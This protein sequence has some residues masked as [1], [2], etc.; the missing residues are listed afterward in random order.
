M[1]PS[2]L[3]AASRF[4]CSLSRASPLHIN[5]ARSAA[6]RDL[7]AE[8]PAD[9]APEAP[10][11]ALAP[12]VPPAT[13][14]PEVPPALAAPDA[15]PPLAALPCAPSTAGGGAEQTLP[16]ARLAQRCAITNVC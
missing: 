6:V 14:A 4:I 5:E 3:P 8:A 11:A 12:E 15:P 16:R 9:P 2:S 13:A 1:A 10:P 7:R